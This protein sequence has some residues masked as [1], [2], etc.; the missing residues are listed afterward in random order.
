MVPLEG[1]ITPDGESRDADKAATSKLTRWK[2][3]KR[4]STNWWQSDPTVI[5]AAQRHLLFATDV[6]ADAQRA[7]AY[8][9]RCCWSSQQEACL[10]EDLSVLSSFRDCDLRK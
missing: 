1:S 5:H 9:L 8:D 7:G 10:Q 2:S 4:S 3:S 6:V